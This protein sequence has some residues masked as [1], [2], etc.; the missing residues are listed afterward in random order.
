[1]TQRIVSGDGA[2]ETGEPAIVIAARVFHLACQIIG[3]RND[4]RVERFFLPVM[5]LAV[6]GVSAFGFNGVDLL[7]VAKHAAGRK[8][9]DQLLGILWPAQFAAEAPTREM[10]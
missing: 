6:T 2:I 7:A 4:H 5:E 9:P 3:G 10:R 1:M 8:A